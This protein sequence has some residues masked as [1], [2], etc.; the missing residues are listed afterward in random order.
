MKIYI[1]PYIDRYIDISHDLNEFGENK[2][3]EAYNRNNNM[4]ENDDMR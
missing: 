3:Q 1:K 2:I 4:I